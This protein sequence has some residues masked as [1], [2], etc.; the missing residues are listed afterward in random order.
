LGRVTE[1]WLRHMNLADCYDAAAASPLDLP[2]DPPI[3][4]P[5]PLQINM[6]YIRSSS[7]LSMDELRV[8][9]VCGQELRKDFSEVH[10]SIMLTDPIEELPEV[11]ELITMDCVTVIMVGTLSSKQAWSVEVK[12]KIL[13]AMQYRQ[14]Q[15]HVVGEGLDAFGTRLKDYAEFCIPF[16]D[17][18]FHTRL[19]KSLGI[20]SRSSWPF[21]ADAEELVA[22][23][24]WVSWKNARAAQDAAIVEA[25]LN[26]EGANHLAD[27][28]E[29]TA[30]F[31]PLTEFF[32]RVARIQEDK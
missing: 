11:D 21:S 15:L 23:A 32:V 14:I 20:W 25:F 12:G 7:K 18:Y 30:E 9:I 1:E 8:R 24:T 13:E 31:G 4:N 3:F 6:M 26:G 17:V 10:P 19:P 29:Y 22:P 16:M 2:D 27:D 28:P 5:R